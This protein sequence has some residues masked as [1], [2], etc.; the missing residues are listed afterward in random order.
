MT[1]LDIRN[2]PAQPPLPF[3]A[4]ADYAQTVLNWAASVPVPLIRRRHVAYGPDPAQRYDVYGEPGSTPLPA[5]VFWH[6]GGW[7]HG[8]KEWCA[9]M[10][11]PVARLGMRLVTPGYRLAPAHPLPAALDDSQSML[12]HLAHEAAGLG[13]D[14]ARLYLAGHSA[15]GHLALLTALR[16]RFRAASGDPATGVIRACLPISGILDLHHPEPPPGSLEERVY[17]MVLA[18]A[19]DD[20]A[21]SPLCWAAGNRLPV[22]LSHGDSDSE[23]VIRSNQRMAALL[24][25]QPGASCL[26]CE[27]GHDHFGTHTALRDARAPWYARLAELVQQSAQCAAASSTHLIPS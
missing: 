12:D 23:R 22:L 3:K 13:V 25:L 6:G 16:R 8:F 9:F 17:S 15:G 7:T 21:M 19:H 10:A 14:P 2:L 1:S 5:L 4:A 18:T 27:A 20:A 24:A 11:E 26:H